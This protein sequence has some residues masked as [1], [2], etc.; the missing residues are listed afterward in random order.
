MKCVAQM[1]KPMA[2]PEAAIDRARADPLR[3]C[4]RRSRWS[5]IRLADAQTNTATA[6]TRQSYSIAMLLKARN[7][8]ANDCELPRRVG[9]MHCLSVNKVLSAKPVVR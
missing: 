4:A 3:T 9:P 8:E 5:A 6:T 7:I 1:L 2:A